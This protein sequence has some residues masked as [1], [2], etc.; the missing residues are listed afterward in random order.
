MQCQSAQYVS[1]SLDACVDRCGA[2][3]LVD[4]EARR[5]TRCPAN[6]FNSDGRCRYCASNNTPNAD[7]TGCDPCPPGRYS[8]SSTQYACQQCTGGRYLSAD[9]T[10][11]LAACDKDEEPVAQTPNADYLCT[12]CETGYTSPYG[13]KCI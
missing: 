1:S 13:L 2:G 9:G 8:D 7:Q 11:C 3:E 5:C 6:Q 12:P 4:E 10:Q